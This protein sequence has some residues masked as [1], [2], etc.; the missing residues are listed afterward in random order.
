MN[1]KVT[2]ESQSEDDSYFKIKPQWDGGFILALRDKLEGR[3]SGKIKLRAK[4]YISDTDLYFNGLELY[5]N[6]YDEAVDYPELTESDFYAIAVVAYCYHDLTPLLNLSAKN[7]SPSDKYYWLYLA[8]SP[9][10]FYSTMEI[11]MFR[12]RTSNDVKKYTFSDGKTKY[13]LFDLGIN[14]KRD[15]PR[16]IEYVSTRSRMGAIDPG[17]DIPAFLSISGT[18]PDYQLNRLLPDSLERMISLYRSDRLATIIK[19][20]IAAGGTIAGGFVNSLV[21]PSYMV[22]N[23]PPP[24]L[25]L[26]DEDPDETLDSYDE[27]GDNFK[28]YNFFSIRT[29]NS[30]N[31]G[32]N[33]SKDVIKDFW[34]IARAFYSRDYLNDIEAKGTGD[35]A[36]VE[37]LRRLRKKLAKFDLKR[38]LAKNKD[39]LF[40]KDGHLYRIFYQLSPDIDIFFSGEDYQSKFNRVTDILLSEFTDR[41][42]VHHTEFSITFDRFVDPLLKLKIQLIK[43]KYNSNTEVLA[44]FDLDSSRV[45]LRLVDGKLDAIAPEAYINSVECGV[46]IMVPCRQSETF[47]KRLK[48]YE[49]RGFELFLPGDIRTRFDMTVHLYSK[50]RNIDNLMSDYTVEFWRPE[51]TGDGDDAIR[52]PPYLQ[53]YVEIFDDV[54][55]IPGWDSIRGEYTGDGYELNEADFSI[56]NLLVYHNHDLD[57]KK[58]CYVSML[59]EIA[60]ADGKI[61]IQ[62]RDV[63][64]MAFVIEKLITKHLKLSQ[65]RTRMRIRSARADDDSEESDDDS[66]ESDDD[67]EGQQLVAELKDI[68]SQV[69][70]LVG[71]RFWN[72]TDPMTQ[73]TGSFNPTQHDYLSGSDSALNPYLE[74][75]VGR[76]FVIDDRGAISRAK[77]NELREKRE[78]FRTQEEEKNETL[79]PRR[80]RLTNFL[81][82]GPLIPELTKLV[83][84]ETLSEADDIYHSLVRLRKRMSLLLLSTHSRFH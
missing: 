56:T 67:S 74:N 33:N 58:R 45:S 77:K 81:T 5:I 30:T 65:T 60:I 34:N 15:V 79:S 20:I 11:E 51:E 83:L 38:A 70:D 17:Y 7:R 52:V 66:E 36:Q 47:A 64:F 2:T 71:S 14:S 63:L 19:N 46:N 16:A 80:K 69:Y 21:N 27:E 32:P 75:R 3:A 10:F 18:I 26:D 40:A 76:R 49:S 48:K 59:R 50:I 61:T 39:V 72:L 9:D 68:T 84:D 42:V 53:D 41:S 8:G 82:G 23:I 22:F 25:V 55:S 24:K 78:K 12:R 62:K 28:K 73:F 1:L 57:L 29:S 37:Y 54:D 35:P 4:K 13:A 44:G 43:R 31:S 6:N